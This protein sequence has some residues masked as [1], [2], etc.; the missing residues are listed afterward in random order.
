MRVQAGGGLVEQQQPRRVQQGLGD[1]QALLEAERERL[2]ER[3]GAIGEPRAR[4]RA[5]HGRAP[6]RSTQPERVREELEELA[7]AH[8]LV[9]AGHVGHVADE[10]AHPARGAD[11]V[12]AVDGRR[13]RVRVHERRQD[14]DER[15][16]AGAVRPHQPH[17]LAALDG[18]REAVEGAERAVALDEVARVDHRRPSE[19]TVTTC[20]ARV[21]GVPV[22]SLFSVPAGP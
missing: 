22:T 7:Y 19:T 20:G 1:E 4:E 5:L 2:D 21:A 13:P 6:A 12:E 3:V 15:R 17:Q 16:L 14:L 10:R 11:H 8:V 9:E 18:E